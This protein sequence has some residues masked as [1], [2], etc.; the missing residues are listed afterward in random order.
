MP[1]KTIR[2]EPKK[3]Y[4]FWWYLLGILL[5]PVLGLGIYIIYKK[6]SELNATHYQITDRTITAVHP[7]YSENI[8]VVN[9]RDVNLEQRW[10]DKQFGTGNLILITNT[11]EMELIGLKNPAA[12]SEMVLQAAETERELIKQQEIKEQKR[13][14][15]L[16]P[17]S[18]ERMNYLT[19][20]W[21]QG[22]ISND[23]YEQ[24]R[25]HFDGD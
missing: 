6:W 4:H 2:L 15:E 5:I 10:I 9:I 1:N 23:E 11:K 13:E 22:L 19:G 18:M 25:K 16:T 3:N 14:P 7:G 21:Q 17:G 20:L 8:D 12:F 24:E